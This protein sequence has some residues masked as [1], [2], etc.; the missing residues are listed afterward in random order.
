MTAISFNRLLHDL[1]IQYKIGGRNSQ[2]KG[3]WV[4]YKEYADKGYT[5]TK[6][7]HLPNG[8]SHIHTYWLQKGRLFLY[9][10]LASVG[11][12]PQTA[13]GRAFIV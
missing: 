8:E 9:N 4:L 12:Y 7:Y 10:V 6:T 11:I 1:G 13:S 3:C 2:N 5:K